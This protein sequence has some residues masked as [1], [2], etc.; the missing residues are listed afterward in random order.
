MAIIGLITNEGLVK[1]RKAQDK[2]GGWKIYPTGFSVSSQIGELISDNDPEVQARLLD[3]TI[4]D[5][6]PTFYGGLISSYAAIDTNTIQLSCNVPAD[7]TSSIVNIREIYIFAKDVNDDDFL[8]A[9]GQADTLAYDPSGETTL[10]LQIRILNANL[11]SL[12]DFHYTQAEELSEHNQNPSAHPSIQDAL[13]SGGLFSEKAQHKYVGQAVDRRFSSES[14]P[15]GATGPTDFFDSQVI[16]KGIGGSYPLVYFD[17][18]QGVYK[19]ALAD[20]S[21][22]SRVVGVADYV[23]DNASGTRRTMVYTSGMVGTDSGYPAGTLLYL[24][25]TNSGQFTDIPS[26]VCVGMSLGSKTLIRIDHGDHDSG[27]DSVCDSSV[28]WFNVNLPKGNNHFESLEDAIA[29]CPEGGWVKVERMYPLESTTPIVL[30]KQ[31]N[32]MFT[33][34]KSGISKFNGTN[35]VQAI[36]FFGV[37]GPTGAGIPYSGG[38]VLQHTGLSGATGPKTSRL[39]YDAD[40]ATIQ[41]ELIALSSINDVVVTRSGV[42]SISITF[43][44]VDG[45][46]PQRNII[47]GEYIGRNEVQLLSF[48]WL[49]KEL[50]GG[51][52]PTDGSFR[53]VYDGQTTSII[54]T[55]NIASDIQAKLIALSNL[56]SVSVEG[57]YING[58]TI[59]FT[60]SNGKKPE[61]LITVTDSSLNYGGVT[62]TASVSVTTA[63]IFPDRD[64]YDVNGDLVTVLGSVIQEGK[65]LG[66]STAIV[67]NHDECQIIGLGVISGFDVGIDF[68]GKHNCKA[69]MIF[70]NNTLS[71]DTDSLYPEDFSTDGSLGVSTN[72]EVVY[73]DTLFRDLVKV[74][75]TPM[76]STTVNISGSRLSLHDG[77]SHGLVIEQVISQYAG[78]SINFEPDIDGICSIYGG[79]DDFLAYT[80]LTPSYYYKYAVILNS[81]DTISVALPTGEA[82]NALDAPMPSVTG[83]LLRA[84]VCVQDDG[85]GGILPIA[86]EH[87]QR[88]HSSG[89]FTPTSSPRQISIISTGTV[90]FSTVPEFTFNASNEVVDIEVSV[91]GVT[92]TLDVTGSGLPDYMKMTNSSIRFSSSVAAPKK[93]VIRLLENVLSNNVTQVS[94]KVKEIDTDGVN[95]EFTLEGWNFSTNNYVN[96]IEVFI[97][98]VPQHLRHNV[99]KTANDKIKFINY[100]DGVTVGTATAF[101]PPS[102]N[103]IVVKSRLFTSGGSVTPKVLTAKKDDLTISDSV[104]TLQ[105]SG[106]NIT[107]EEDPPGNLKV[108][109]IESPL[110]TSIVN[111]GSGVGQVFAEILSNALKLRNIKAGEGI[112]VTIVG[113]DIIISLSGTSYFIEHVWGISG[114]SIPLEQAYNVGTKRL[115]PYRNGVRM[116][117]SPSVG[118]FSQ[119]FSEMN[120]QNIRIYTTA[121]I[122]DLFTI[123]NEGTS[124]TYQEIITDQVGLTISIPTYQVGDGRLKVWRN[125]VL[126]NTSGQGAATSRYAEISQSQILLEE[127]AESSDVFIVE[128]ASVA[129]MWRCELT[130]VVGNTLT[131]PSPYV[132]GDTRLILYRNGTLMFNSGNDEIGYPSYRYTETT[133]NTV[134]LEDGA[135][136]S[137][138]FTAIYK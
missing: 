55:E 102:G 11:S 62:V 103:L 69:E 83:G 96:D 104:S 88:F 107:V 75:P 118:M 41:S 71:V 92:K 36:S 93:V 80:A 23:L 90:N 68:N 134:T 49:G 79:G 15:S 108:S 8:L 98:A 9:F 132:V 138:V 26:D 13:S 130:S 125:G 48:D 97:N 60:G 30:D 44:G 52:E 105:F 40:A 63:G 35:E 51:Q 6:L 45:L 126:M 131:F 3:R 16:S 18:Y 56:S 101:V 113:D 123:I 127:E 72:A 65:V 32:L 29:N 67:I 33:G 17:E 94:C 76:P 121:A 21:E 39:A 112:S 42:G 136:L 77:S 25:P 19:L 84:V 5:I 50:G 116:H 53:L 110:F 27:F 124:P 135:V 10:R 85:E 37:T 133:V 95:S 47:C 82:D 46:T 81:D 61:H 66:S 87:I 4:A 117:L 34:A 58:F 137:D 99:I 114:I 128:Y 119:R 2:E 14:L 28:E 100:W 86:A 106:S 78:G 12:Y 74:S 109:V 70:D 43:S 129:P 20:G 120:S 38:F 1:T 57:S 24:H 7:Q 89:Q 73:N 111:S 91:D 122:D 64:V 54:S 31:I 115:T 59:T 22:K